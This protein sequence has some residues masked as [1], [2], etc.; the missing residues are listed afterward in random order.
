MDEAYQPILAWLDKGI[1]RRRLSHR[2]PEGRRLSV[3]ACRLSRS[4]RTRA[5]A[6]RGTRQAQRAAT[7]ARKEL[8]VV[9][10]ALEEN[11]ANVVVASL[12]SQ[13]IAKRLRKAPAVRLLLDRALMVRPWGQS[14]ITRWRVAD[15]RRPRARW[16]MSCSKCSQISGLML[17][18]SSS[19]I[20][21]SITAIA[22]VSRPA[23]RHSSITA[24]K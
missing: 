24:V 10:R 4:A 6:C 3:P 15:A 11:G 13:G 20:L 17:S 7:R 21:P 23:M 12:R 8:V 5:R 18:T 14:S 19:F 22:L 16:A 1:P 9:R 2:A